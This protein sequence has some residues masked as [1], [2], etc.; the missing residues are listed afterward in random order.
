MLVPKRI[1][2]MLA[3][4]TLALPAT[5]GD[6]SEEWYFFVKNGTDHRVTN[7]EVSIDKETWGKFEIGKGIQPGNTVKLVWAPETNDEPC[8][9]W[10]RAT[11]DDGKTGEAH[12][13][14]FCQDLDEP[15]EFGRQDSD[16]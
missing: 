4:L 12:N 7:L 3:T 8:E 2:L 1:C 16:Q 6:D 11:Y 5:A 10:L 14:N 9:Q 13:M 15:I